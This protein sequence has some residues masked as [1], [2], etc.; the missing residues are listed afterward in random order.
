[1]SINF[2]YKDQETMSPALSKDQP[3]CEIGIVKDFDRIDKHGTKI[4]H[5]LT[6]FSKENLYFASSEAPS[7][8]TTGQLVTFER[9][10]FKSDSGNFDKAIAINHLATEI[11]EPS[12]RKLCGESLNQIFWSLVAADHLASLDLP[13]QIIWLKSR[14][15]QLSYMPITAWD[16]LNLDAIQDPQVWNMIP[17]NLRV[18]PLENAISLFHKEYLSAD[19]IFKESPASF[20]PHEEFKRLKVE[21]VSKW[22]KQ[23][24]NLSLDN[25]QAAA[26]AAVSGDIQVIARAGS[27]KTRSLVT[28][29]IFLQKHCEVAPHEI[30]L[31]AFNK[32][33]AKEIK[34]RLIKTLKNN[35]PHVMTFHALAHA[36]VHPEEELIYD[37]SGTNELGASNE[38]Q[39]VIDDHIQSPIYRN[40]IME[41]MLLYFRE[42]WER[43]EN[44]KFTIPMEEFLEHRRSLQRETL[45]GDY[46][47][48]YGEKLIANILFEHD[49]DYKYESNF[50]W[51]GINYRPDF[52]ISTIKNGGVIIEYFGLNGEPDYDK[53]SDEKRNFWAK[54]KEWE[55]LEYSPSDIAK[56][57]AQKFTSKMVNDLR[58]LGLKVTR[59]PEEEIWQRIRGRA[60]DS[61]TKAMK[62]FVGRC[63]KLYLTEEELENR[64]SA[65]NSYLPAEK[66]FLQVGQTIYAGYIR[67]L[68]KNQKE[69]FDGLMWR[70]VTEIEGG[71]TKF[72][73]DRGKENGDLRSLRYIMVDEFQDFS[74]VFLKLLQA[75][76]KHNQFVEFFCVGDDWQAINGFAGSDL[77]YFENFQEYFSDPTKINI[78][79][80]HRSAKAIVDVGNSLMAGL[81]APA[82]S[83]D[84]AE[85]G[86]VVIGML[87]K[88]TPTAI[89][90]DRHNGD[91]ITPAILRL[92]SDYLKQDM[93]VVILSRTN[94]RVGYY[95]NYTR[96]N[97]TLSFREEDRERITVS[98]SHK[99]KGLERPA[100]IVID[101]LDRSYPLIH[102]HWIFLRLF[103]SSVNQ[104]VAEEM[105]LFYVALTRAEKSLTIITESNRQSKFLSNVESGLSK[106]T[107]GGKTYG[108][109]ETKSASSVSDLFGPLSGQLDWDSLTPIASQGA[110]KLEIRVRNAYD[111]K[112]NLIRQGFKWENKGKY[113]H[114][115]IQQEKFEIGAILNQEWAKE[116]NAE[117]MV[118]SETGTQ[119]YP[120]KPNPDTTEVD[121]PF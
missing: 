15:N 62:S 85:N 61:F 31:L 8:I 118:F 100:V 60:I 115:T 58:S 20:P 49:I 120:D 12:V 109:A 29:A 18:K 32:K 99:F 107:I 75:I 79:T 114:K 68:I 116:S 95:V 111:I 6:D 38:V 94:G 7:D 39:K 16:S 72:S 19:R 33:A 74:E 14:V 10:V 2:E 87:D 1:M 9:G 101:A 57:G 3:S 89:E 27:G 110:P 24:L 113:W 84:N 28:R 66:L 44:G 70:A 41:L 76:R 91:D 17:T 4:G 50:H 55:F 80:N 26:V 34:E 36:I 5:I 90:S 81:G 77:K 103:G 30:L 47:K 48:S 112:D 102:S 13:S 92:V 86:K 108:R 71:H 37:N 21:Y 42:D 23:E 106:T 96:E 52:K 104:I 93:S 45:K 97:K 11:N 78:Q 83:R 119:I 56:D 67:N 51:S 69:D 117:I 43:I 35:V 54:K 53:M 98:T 46:V 73:R 82:R 88:F 40:L 121:L 22:A 64:I 25:E 63:R 59:L 65:H 105:R